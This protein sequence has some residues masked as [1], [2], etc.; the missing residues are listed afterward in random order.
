MACNDL[1][2]SMCGGKGI[3]TMVDVACFDLYFTGL[4]DLTVLVGEEVN[5]TEGVHAYDGNGVEAKFRYDPT[6]ID[7]SRTGTYTVTYI[8]SGYGNGIRPTICGD[9]AVHTTVCE[10]DS[11][12]GYRTVTVE[13]NEAIACEASVCYSYVGCEPKPVCEDYGTPTWS[14]SGVG[15]LVMQ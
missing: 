13:P 9:D 1:K 2:P 10:Y 4:T 3:P 11:V 12:T 8:A 5:L 7:T 14:G 15:S 6:S